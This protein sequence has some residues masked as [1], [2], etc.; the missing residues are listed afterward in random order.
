MTTQTYFIDLY[1][2]TA[3]WHKD[4]L[5]VLKWLKDKAHVKVKARLVNE[6]AVLVE[7]LTMLSKEEFGKASAKPEMPEQFYLDQ[8]L[9][10]ALLMKRS[11]ACVVINRICNENEVT[12]SEIINARSADYVTT[13]QYATFFDYN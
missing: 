7:V 13:T 5:T 12:I 8:Q 3:K 1:I 6:Q 10:A 2:P 4:A 11:D 9:K